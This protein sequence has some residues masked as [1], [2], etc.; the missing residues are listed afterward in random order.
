MTHESFTDI[1]YG[2]MKHALSLSKRGLGTTAPN[3]SVGCVL[4]KNN[5]VIGQGWTQPGGRPH[6][7]IH[8][9]T[10]AVSS[11]DGATAYVTLEPCAHKGQSGAC[12]DAL[13]QA[14]VKRV[15]IASLDPNP[16]VNGKG[17][18]DLKAAGIAVL[19]GCMKEEADKIH[20]G[21]FFSLQ[22]NRPLY[23]AKIASSLDGKIA[24]QCG[25]SKWIT[26]DQSRMRGHSLRANHDA[27]LI[28]IGT[29][30]ADNPSLTCRLK[31]LENQSPKRI[32]MDRQLRIP[33]TSEL[34]LSAEKIPTYIFTEV[35][36]SKDYPPSVNIITLN[37]IK[38]LKE[39]SRVFLSLGLTRVLIEGGA[40]LLS[41][42]IEEDF[43]DDI[44]WFRSNQVIGADGLSAIRSLAL[45]QLSDAKRYKLQELLPLGT[46][47]L[48]RRT[49]R[50]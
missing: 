48:E 23:T 33:I 9:L 10:S 20:R 43:V 29:A 42:F 14:N 11:P 13:I 37:N 15:I 40:T 34:V 50:R 32:V 31:G 49:R 18:E 27:I 6:A 35:S 12:T 7:E 25:E 17:I 39:V 24:L 3:P 1:D 16:Q 26:N 36:N 44:Y 45:R 4:V 30:L 22:K 2:F 46:D 41:A 47:I 21:F 5:H 38:D 8:A 19:S 28:G